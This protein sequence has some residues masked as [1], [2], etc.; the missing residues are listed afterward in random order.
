MRHLLFATV[1][2]VGSTTHPPTAAT[3]ATEL[4]NI[5]SSSATAATSTEIH[6]ES[7]CGP[8]GCMIEVEQLRIQRDKGFFEHDGKPL[9]LIEHKPTVRWVL[10]EMDWTP[11]AAYKI[12]TGGQRWGTCLE[13]AHSGI[14]KSGVHQRWSSVVLVPFHGGKPVDAA[15]RFVGYWTGCDSLQVGEKP[16]QVVLPLVEPAATGASPSLCI[17]Q[18]LCNA[19]GCERREDPRQVHGDPTGETGVLSIDG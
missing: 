12:D 7:G 14:G 15:H 11:I 19:Q 18:Y 13:F 5:L 17:S 16:H 8:A 10:P 2:L 1:L 9:L 3:N 4:R 6:I